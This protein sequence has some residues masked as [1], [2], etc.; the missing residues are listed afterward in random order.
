MNLL[1]I[2]ADGQNSC[3]YLLSLINGNKRLLRVAPNQMLNQ[4]EVA[5]I[6]NSTARLTD[7]RGQLENYISSLQIDAPIFKIDRIVIVE[8][9]ALRDFLFRDTEKI[10]VQNPKDFTWHNQG[11]ADVLF[12][13]GKLLLNK[14]DFEQFISYQEDTPGNLGIFERQEHV[15]RLIKNQ[16]IEKNNPVMITRRFKE[17]TKLVT[18]DLKLTDVMKLLTIYQ[19]N[20]RE[21]IVRFTA[22]GTTNI[23]L[24]NVW[25]AFLEA[26]L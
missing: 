2:L 25:K 12:K 1:F 5:T 15:L 7:F 11:E 26:N 3:F 17:F 9:E 20:K 13:R 16:V 24:I 10:T 4:R 8:T 18:S 22:G 14:N 21:K 6:Y 23:D 19:V